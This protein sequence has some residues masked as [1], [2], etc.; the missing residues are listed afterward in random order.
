MQPRMQAITLEIILRV[1]FGIHERERLDR[2]RAAL[3]RLLDIATA[4]LALV[5]QAAPR[6]GPLLD[7]PA[8][9]RRARGGR[10]SRCSTRSPAAVTPADLA[11]RD[12]ILSLL[13]QAR[14]EDGDPLS[15]RELRD[16]LITLLVAGH[17]TTATALAWACERIVRTPGAVDRLA[18][19]ARPGE[20]AFADAV[21]NETLRLRQPIPVVARKARA[22]RTS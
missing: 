19:E 14:D 1:V 13:V 15:D 22:S 17:E 8:A 2:M 12:D 20:T 5:P 11:E 10:R 4:P 3:V 18:E 21:V 16:E 6:P 7:R 9:G